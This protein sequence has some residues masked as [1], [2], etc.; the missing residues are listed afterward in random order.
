MVKPT[1]IKGLNS[2]GY[3][4]MN[5]KNWLIE[6]CWHNRPMI[7]LRHLGRFIKRL[8]KWLK[9]SWNT[10][11]WD[12][13]GIY[14]FLDMQLREMRKAHEK[15]TWHIQSEVKRSIKQIDLVLLHLDMYRNL[16]KYIDFPKTE[17]VQTDELHNGKPTYK[18]EFIDKVHGEEQFKEFLR[19]EQKHHNKFWKLLKQWHTNWW[20]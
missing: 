11:S 1:F 9:L 18:I 14:D 12:Y 16:D 10:E 19:L 6:L 17:T 8:P 3:N 7:F 15:D 2:D 20:T 5:V 13:E 4:K